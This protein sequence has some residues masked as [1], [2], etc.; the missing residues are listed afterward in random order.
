M[1]SN[2]PKEISSDQQDVRE[3]ITALHQDRQ[4]TKDKERRESWTKYVSLMI[5]VLAVATAIGSLKSAAFGARV[6]LNQAQASDT[7]AFYQ[8]KSIKQRLAEMEARANPGPVGT[9]A[10]ADVIRYQTEEQELQTKAKSFEQ[11]RDA[12]SRHGAPL[13]FSIASLQIAIALASVAL[14]TKRKYLWGASTLLGLVGIAY[15][16]Y[17]LFGV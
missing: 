1:N 14:I 2:T 13:G 16:F 4:S 8:A 6:M 15:L 9:R 3:L 10:A 11:I 5:V 12:A 7:W 17:G